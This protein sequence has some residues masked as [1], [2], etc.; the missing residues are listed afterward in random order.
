MESRKP[1]FS[2]YKILFKYLRTL[3]IV[4][5]FQTPPKK[6][7]KFLTETNIACKMD[8]YIWIGLE[9]HSKNCL[10]MLPIPYKIPSMSELSVPAYLVAEDEQV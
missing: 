7:R 1:Y 10:E 9:R 6:L 4:I 8:V 3:L 2:K 5:I